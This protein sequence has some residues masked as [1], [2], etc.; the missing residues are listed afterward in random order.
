M[1]VKLGYTKGTHLLFC[2]V[3]LSFKAK[4]K[5]PSASNYT[6]KIVC[7]T[8]TVPLRDITLQPFFRLN[9]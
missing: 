9:T 7:I 1:I 3:G 5:T 2:L 8:V 6:C 4:C